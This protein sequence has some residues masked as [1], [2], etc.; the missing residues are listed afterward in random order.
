MKG[1]G[2]RTIKPDD[3]I[4]VTPDAKAK[5]H[6]V[7]IDAVGVC[8]HAMSDTHSL[9]KKP[10]VSFKALL[11]KAIDKNA[12]TGDIESLVYRLSRLNRKLSQE[13]KDEITDAN[14]GKSLVDIEKTLLDGIDPDKR[15]EKAK[16]QFHT[17]EPTNDQIRTVSK[18]MIDEA[19]KVFDSKKL[20]KT[21]LDIK[22][23]NEQIIDDVSIDELLEAGFLDKVQNIDKKTIENWSEFIEK[24]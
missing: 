6:F 13:D 10:N 4:A 18:Q 20:R 12:D 8:E 24:K 19:C 9:S 3:L 7:I 17:E 22:S 14:N 23:K 21:I 16:E 2:T 5:T 11:D 1:R 15:V